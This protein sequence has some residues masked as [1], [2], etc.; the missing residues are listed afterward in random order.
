MRILLLATAFNSLTQ[1]V[2]VELA[3]AGH[4][5]AVGVV[6]D[7]DDM[8]AAIESFPPDVIVAPYL[9]S[10]I[11]ESIWRSYTCLIVHPGIRGDR[12][13]SSL[14]W[15]I[16]RGERNW[17]VTVLQATAEL[18][19]GAIW[20][21]REFPM[22][23]VSKSALYRHEVADAAAEAVLEALT[24]FAE[25]GY[26][27]EPP[28]RHPEIRGRFEPPMR[29]RDRAIDWTAPTEAVLRRLLCA[30]SHPGVLDTLF[31]ERYYLFDGHREEH[32]N[33]L[34]GE[35]V[36]QR[37]GAICRATG[38]GAVWITHL[39]PPKAANSLHLKLPATVV[40]GAHLAAVPKLA[41]FL[42]APGDATA[43]REVWYEEHNDVGYLHFEFY[44][45]AMSAQQC[46]TLREAYLWACGRPT[47]VIVLMG[48]QD[49][50]SNGIDL[51]AIEAA[52]IPERESWININTMNDIV[53]EIITTDSH[54]VISALAGNAGAG[55]VPLALATDEVYARAGIVLNPHY[56]KM[57]LYGS[58]YWTYL[59]PRRIGH[60]G[61]LDLTESCL[62][63]STRMAK[64]IGLID[65]VFGSDLAGFRDTIR[66]FAESLARSADFELRLHLKRQA[67]QR[68][69]RT[70]ALC[71]YRGEELAKMAANFGDPRYHQSRQDF[72][73]KRQPVRSASGFELLHHLTDPQ[74]RAYAALARH[75]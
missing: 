52:A 72:V 7:A 10:V 58:E 22:R 55:G 11:P 24:R 30:D 1:R 40:L 64:K 14:D 63:I 68:E 26:I 34:P 75:S 59:L 17:G 25:G 39:K 47:K 42:E 53:R 28:D 71:T 43:Y 50:W 46:R 21:Y 61:A 29:Q 48:G 74:N 56:K 8:V 18:D 35:L 57:G 2:Y 66:R 60:E 65:D 19:A 67:R 51:N 70:K 4:D 69:E 6:G 37:G 62:P 49:L 13:P 12:G 15:A 16:L 32:L 27:P 31:G 5:L 3:D 36:A 33:G 54:W 44:N 20:S 9:K 45:G 38:D 73:Y 23:L 41:S